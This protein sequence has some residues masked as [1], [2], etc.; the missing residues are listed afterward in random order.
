M[1]MKVLH[2]VIVDYNGTRQIARKIFGRESFQRLAIS[3]LIL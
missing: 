2:D 3:T 1:K